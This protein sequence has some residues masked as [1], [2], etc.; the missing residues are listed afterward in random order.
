MS[1]DRGLLAGGNGFII[2]PGKAWLIEM[3]HFQVI[4]LNKCPHVHAQRDIEIH[5]HTYIQISAHTAHAAI[6]YAAVS[7]SYDLYICS[8][9]R[10]CRIV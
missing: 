7:T 9:W 6:W 4:H 1:P 5:S 3:K 10:S 2:I 8:Q